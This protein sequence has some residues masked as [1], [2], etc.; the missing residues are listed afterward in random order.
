MGEC[1]ANNIN[2]NYFSQLRRLN[3]FN[4][5]FNHNQIESNF[6]FWGEGENWRTRRKTSWSRVMHLS[7]VWPRI[8]GRATQGIFDIIFSGFQMSISPPLGLHHKS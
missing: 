4:P 5:G 2:N 6:V 3:Q 8:G 1:E 7:M